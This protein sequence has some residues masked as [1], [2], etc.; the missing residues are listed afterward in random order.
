MRSSMGC[1]GVR[2][3]NSFAEI[4]L[5][6]TEERA[7]LAGPFMQK[8]HKPDGMSSATEK[9]SATA[10]AGTRPSIADE[11]S[12]LLLSTTSHGSVE[13]TTQSAVRNH[14]SNST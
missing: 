7:G 1:S 4:I 5:L 3:A 13:K 8:K 9:G 10:V 2:W 12:S 6:S 14:R 11:R